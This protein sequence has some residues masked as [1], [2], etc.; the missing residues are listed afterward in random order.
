MEM[1]TGNLWK[2]IFIYSLPLMLTHLLEL[3]FNIADVAIAGKFAG[4]I[5]LGAVGSTSM[6]ITL[7][8]GWLIGISNGVNAQVAFYIGEM[9]MTRKKEQLQQG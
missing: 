3:F 2:K 8:T 5:S 6:L 1:R 4:P 9:S 7:T